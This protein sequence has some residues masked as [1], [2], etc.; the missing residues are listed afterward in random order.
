MTKGDVMRSTIVALVLSL[1]ACA[2]Q[3]QQIYRWVDANGRVQYSADKP[4]AGTQS[5]VVQQRVNS[6]GGNA[7]AAAK[8]A[9]A[10]GTAKAP[11]KMFG[12]DWCPYCKQAREYFSRNGIAYSELDIEKSGAAK[13]EYQGIGG[14]GVPVIF[15]GSERMNGFSEQRMAQMLKAAGY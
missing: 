7:A 2:V 13:S 1:I 15:V 8:T 3:A 12:T 6:V 11:V 5:N 10:G 9:A 4:P 14:R